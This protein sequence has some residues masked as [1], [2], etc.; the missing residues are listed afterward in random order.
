MVYTKKVGFDWDPRKNEANR[1]KHGIGFETAL[2]AFDDPHAWLAVDERHSS[3]SEVREILIGESDAGVLVV[4]FTVRE[5]GTLLRIISARKASGRERRRYE[6][7]KK[8]SL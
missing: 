7:A 5:S 6:E 8:F 1:A 3:A 2:T 4:I